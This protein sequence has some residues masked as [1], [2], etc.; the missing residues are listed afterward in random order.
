MDDL[1]KRFADLDGLRAPDLWDEIEQH[2]AA[3]GSAGSGAPARVPVSARAPGI[4]RRA[5]AVLAAAALLVALVLQAMGAGS[6]TLPQANRS[7][8]PALGPGANG[9]IAYEWEEDIYV[10]DPTTGETRAIVS[11]PEPDIRPVFSPDGTTVAFLRLGATRLDDRI[12]V[13][14]PDGSGQRVVVPAGVSAKGMDGPYWTPDS[15]AIVVVHNGTTNETPYW[16]G[17]LS[18]FDAIGS[19]GR[20]DLTPPL[21]PQPGGPFFAPNAG[22]AP[23]FRPPSGDLILSSWFSGSAESN[24]GLTWFDAELQP[25]GQLGKTALAE[26]EPYFVESPAWSPDG[27]TIA[28]GLARAGG[29]Q[30]LGDRQGFLINADGTGLRPI[31]AYGQW[32]PDGTMIAGERFSE[33]PDAEGSVIV[34]VDVTRGTEHELEVT[35]VLTKIEGVVRDATNPNFHSIDGPEGRFLEQ[36]GGRPLAVSVETGAATELPW[37]MNSAPS[38]QRVAVE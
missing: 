27:S 28:F 12:L 26:Y 34:I 10:G 14:R 24:A 17:E 9:L 7:P 30:I 23:I 8:A 15:S 18:M 13:V 36:H 19:T 20:R 22:V 31:S 2:A 5:L 4:D 29:N 35:A 16:D 37:V 33:D 25:L 3:L 38:W 11:G 1:R 32:S 21:A 6:M